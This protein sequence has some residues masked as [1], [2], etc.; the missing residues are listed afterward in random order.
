MR[1]AVLDDYQDVARGLADWQSAGEPSFFHDHVS[2]ENALV[3]RLADYEVIVAM[4]ERTPFPRELLERLPKLRLLVTTGMRNR[5]ID[6]AAAKARGVAVCGTPGLNTT[7]AELAWGLILALA[8]QIPREDREL[9]TGRWQ[10]SVG[11]GLAGKTLG[12]LGLGSIGQQVARV[13]AAF[14]MKL[15]A[16]SQNLKQEKANLAGAQRVEREELFAQADVLTIHL[17]LSERTRGLVGARELALMKRSAMLVNT[18]RGPIVD[19]GALAEAL[20][21]GAIAGAGIDVYG[22]EPIPRDHPLLV[23]P[24]TVLTPHLGYV[25]RESYRVYYEGAVEAIRAWQQ[26]A[27]VRLL[28]E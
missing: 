7:T 23:A 28:Q 26:G 19:E 4:R 5:S 27:P 16:W 10:T 8:R 14:G 15:I 13:G 12:I 24:N 25:T 18:S 20:K 9:R 6:L 3:Q 11:I 1:I 17:V 2:E 21:R 22:E